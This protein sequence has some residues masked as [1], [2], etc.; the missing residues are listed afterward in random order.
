M[1][2]LQTLKEI[3]KYSKKFGYSHLPKKKKKSLLECIMEGDVP[4]MPNLA[5]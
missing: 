4:A 3:D 1:W 2:G 5:L